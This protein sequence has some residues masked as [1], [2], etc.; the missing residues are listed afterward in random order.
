MATELLSERR[1]AALVLTLRD[2]AT[3]NALSPEANAAG[4][5]AI[6]GAE[7]DPGI[8]A[9]VLRG[10]GAHFCAGG[11][12]QR[13]NGVRQRDP[14]EQAQS[15][16]RFHGFVEAIRACPKPVIAAVEGWAAGGGA[17]PVL[18]CDLVVAAEDARFVFSYGRIGLSPDGGSSWH[19]GRLLPR[20]VALRMAWLPEPMTAR[21]W[22]A[23]GLVQEVS[24]GG[25]APTRALELAA[26]LAAMR[27]RHW[28]A[29]R[30]GSAPRPT[31]ICARSSTP[32][33]T[34]SSATSSTA[35]AAKACRRPSRSGRHASTSRSPA[36]HG[37]AGAAGR[38]TR[39]R[40]PAPSSPAPPAAVRCR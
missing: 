22:Q 33:V 1:D 36:A 16:E 34:T 20:G 37:P 28:R 13:L 5:E 32:S 4:I 26:Q 6:N 39:A 35:A 8:R 27:R 21:E 18:A 31:S 14:D 15:M 9:I 11:N 25:L 29:P 40:R 10:D 2:P 19:L 12:V 30:S 23:R 3:R 38:A 7:S 17:G 24:D